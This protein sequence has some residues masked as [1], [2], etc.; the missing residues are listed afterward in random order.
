MSAKKA[1]AARSAANTIASRNRRLGLI[2]AGVVASMVALSFASA[3]LYRLFCQATG[4]GGATLRAD[5]A[6]ARVLDRT[7][8]VRFNADTDPGLPWEFKPAQREIKVKLGEQTLAY[9]T[10][11]NTSRET[12]TGTAAFN[13]TPDKAGAYFDKLQCFC[14]SEQ[15]LAPGQSADLPVSF[16]VDPAMAGD[17]NMDD[18][19]AITL[20]YTFFRT[21]TE[22]ARTSQ[23][24]PA[25]GKP[26]N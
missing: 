5:R 11:R 17:G 26:L 25:A 15:T 18:V 2:C 3:P 13:V 4:F 14:F 22:P 1:I 16:F 12:V 24:A 6:P 19:T 20:S 10:A 8:A 7:V 23:A 9:Y 21:K